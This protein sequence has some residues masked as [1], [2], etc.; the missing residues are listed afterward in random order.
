MREQLKTKRQ[1]NAEAVRKKAQKELKKTKSKE[2]GQEE[3]NSKYVT[4][5]MVDYV[6]LMSSRKSP[7]DLVAQ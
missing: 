6:K 2:N 4:D 3:K 1:E 7:K 5:G